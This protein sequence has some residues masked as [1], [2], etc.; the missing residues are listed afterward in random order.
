MYL[1][2]GNYNE[3]EIFERIKLKEELGRFVNEYRT[4]ETH[5]SIEEAT[6]WLIE[7]MGDNS[8]YE[9][10]HMHVEKRKDEKQ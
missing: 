8:R 7:N 1:V 2:E 6:D 5:L 4:M 10:I 3:N 9:L